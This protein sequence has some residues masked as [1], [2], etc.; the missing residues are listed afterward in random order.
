MKLYTDKEYENSKMKDLLNFKC[1]QCDKVFTRI[2]NTKHRAVRDGVLFDYCDWKCVGIAKKTGQT[3]N[4]K[5]CQLPVYRN[6]HELRKNDGSV[7]CSISCC[8]TFNNKLRDWNLEWPDDR[9]RCASNHAKANPSGFVDPAF[10]NTRVYT[11][12]IPNIPL[13]CQDCKIEFL[14]KPRER[15]RKFC[16]RKCSN[17]HNYH[18]TTTKYTGQ[19]Y[20]GQWFDSGSEVKF[21]KLLNEHKIKWI[22]NSTIS[23]PFIDTDNRNRRYFPDFYLPDL[24]WWVEIKGRYY[25]R[26]HDYLRIKAVGDNI[27]TIFHDEIRL[28]KPLLI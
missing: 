2:K 28:P 23:F 17:K 5:N 14:V 18:P 10:I 16:S 4:C 7:F 26:K 1:D 24:N 13:I 9:R 25:V 12:I 19:E 6:K 8:A 21:V 11:K 20:E 15:T 3:I 27:E 22:K